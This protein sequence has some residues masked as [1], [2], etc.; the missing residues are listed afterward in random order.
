MSEAK[1]FVKGPPDIG[2]GKS[3]SNLAVVV[4]AGT[5]VTNSDGSVS[6]LTADATFYIQKVALSDSKGNTIEEL[7]DKEIQ[8]RILNELTKLRRGLGRMLKDPELLIDDFD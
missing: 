2:G 3:I 1:G 5:V 4:P 7:V 8:F 6:T